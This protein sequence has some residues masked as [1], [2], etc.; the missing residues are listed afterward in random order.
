MRRSPSTC[1]GR[2]PATRCASPGLPSCAS[3]S[4]QAAAQKKMVI[5]AP[6]IP[7]IYA[8]VILYV[9]EKEGL[10]KK[11]GVDVEVRPFETGTAAAR[12]VLTGDIDISLSP[13]TLIINQISNA[14]APVV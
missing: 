1:R 4:G 5:A 2:V 11:H 13:T 7:P 9:A 14:N 6:G 8:S 3:T 12:A 10:F